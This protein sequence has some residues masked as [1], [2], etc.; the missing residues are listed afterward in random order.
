MASSTVGRSG[1]TPPTGRASG[2]P[3]GKVRTISGVEDVAGYR[4]LRSAGRGDRT[5]LL[6]GFDDGQ[7]VVLKQTTWH[8]PAHHREVE[9][10]TRA[11]GEHV[12]GLIDVA[13]DGRDA[14]IV[15]ERLT[16]G[17]L[18]ELL[19]RRG[20]LDAGEAVTILA[21]LAA[22]LDRIHAAGV[23]HGSLALSSIGFRDDGAPTLIGFGRAELFAPGAP[24]IVQEAIPGVIADRAA[25]RTVAALVLGRIAGDAAPA[26]G[27]LV[28]SLPSVLPAGLGAALFDLAMPVPVRFDDDPTGFGTAR[29][30]EPQ[31]ADPA[32]AAAPAG[33]SAWLAAMA[34]DGLR[35]RVEGILA[36][37]SRLRAEVSAR[38]TRL[39]SSRRRIALGVLAGGLTVAG[40]IAF[41]PP[42]PADSPLAAR[43]TAPAESPLP[44]TDLPDDPV[45][46]AVL[47]IATRNRCL[48]EVS[49]LCL[50]AVTQP[51]SAAYEADAALIRSVQAGGEYPADR[52]LDGEPVLVEQLGDSALLDLPAGS[53]PQSLLLLKTTNGWRIRG[54][55]D[56][57][58]I[59]EPAESAD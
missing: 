4:V 39:P 19:E 13:S 51:G 6:L 15:L 49:Q 29:V 52:I 33:I 11:A 21:P 23:A 8:D 5:R 20:T 42:A 30:G 28:A 9:A 27:R 53:V 10:L 37:L 3:P 7:T 2:A 25:L 14:V 17:T 50:D 44:A 57:P 54:Y 40:A 38:W 45:E 34:P 18:A 26:A 56:A 22:T 32:E 59:Q 36:R 35:E 43:N 31:P 1:E 12:V 55:L 48:R 58:T 41:V 24:E 47:L 16:G 46:A